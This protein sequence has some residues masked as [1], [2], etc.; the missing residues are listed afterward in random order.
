[1]V[2][3]SVALEDKSLPELQVHPG[4]HQKR[5]EESDFTGYETLPWQEQAVIY[6]LPYS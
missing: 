3:R 4:F 1:M 5:P 6:E 2:I